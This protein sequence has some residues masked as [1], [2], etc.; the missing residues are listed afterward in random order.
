M[1]HKIFTGLVAA[2]LCGLLL[3]TILRPD[4]MVSPGKPIEAHAH[5]A[6]DCFA[7]H[8]PFS[9][10]TADKCIVCH[11]VAEIGKKTTKGIPINKE[12]K[13]VAFHQQLLQNDCVSCHS[14]HKGVK[15]FRPISRF[16]HQLLQPALQKECNSCHNSSRDALHQKIVGN[17]SVCHVQQHWTPATFSHDKYFRFDRDHNAECRVCHI[18]N[19]FSKY[20]CYGCHEHSRSV[21]RREHAEEGIFN[22]ESCAGCHR[23]ANEDEAKRLW[24][25]QRDKSDAGRARLDQNISNHRSDRHHEEE[26]DDD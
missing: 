5:L 24:R 3:L 10:S 9:G 17:C 22:Y 16:S 11:K 8:T 21:I 1:N 7:C 20:T 23:S 26:E 12:K 25:L 18:E 4:L 2:A 6:L 14:D 13:N 15:A 19:D